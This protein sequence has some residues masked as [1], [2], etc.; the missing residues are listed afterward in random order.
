[1]KEIKLKKLLSTVRE[2]LHCIEE[3]KKFSHSRVY[4][5]KENLQYC[6]DEFHKL[7]LIKIYDEKVK[8]F[9]K[10]RTITSISISMNEDIRIV[11]VE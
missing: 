11:D 10:E 7:G 5:V 8:L 2:V 3:V 1:M 6:L 4:P 9:G